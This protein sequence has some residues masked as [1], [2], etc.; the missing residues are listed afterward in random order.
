MP[1][2]NNMLRRNKS[3]EP[4]VLIIH[5]PETDGVA[6]WRG[7]RLKGLRSALGLVGHNLEVIN[8]ETDSWG[9]ASVL[10]IAGRHDVVSFSDS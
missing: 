6:E 4:P 5:Y 1:L 7:K 9:D 8:I 10:I 3:F 2:L